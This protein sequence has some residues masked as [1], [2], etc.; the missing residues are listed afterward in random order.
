[1]VYSK[2]NTKAECS[3]GVEH[4]SDMSKA[5]GSVSGTEQRRS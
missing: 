4:L 5:L 2:Q 3:S 1:M